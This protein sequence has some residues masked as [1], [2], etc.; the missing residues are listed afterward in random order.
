MTS[1]F[2]Y[3]SRKTDIPEND[4]LSSQSKRILYNKFTWAQLMNRIDDEIGMND[5]TFI[6]AIIH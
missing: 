2:K 1:A 6:S 4:F 3:E 5:F